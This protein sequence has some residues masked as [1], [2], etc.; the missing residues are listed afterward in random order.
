MYATFKTERDA[1]I[2]KIHDFV[3]SIPQLTNKYR[4][5]NLYINI[6]EL[7]KPTTDSVRFR[8]KW[9]VGCYT[10][11]QDEWEVPGVT[12]SWLCG[13]MLG[14]RWSAAWWR[15]TRSTITWRT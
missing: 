4:G 5:L 2:D 10:G 3:K 14:S 13:V 6:A 1:S 15:G 7:L 12:D 8:Q 9:Q 11:R